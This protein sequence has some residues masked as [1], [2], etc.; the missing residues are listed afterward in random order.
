[1]VSHYAEYRVSFIVMLSVVM[2]NVVAPHKLRPYQKKHG[3]MLDGTFIFFE[4]NQ[5]LISEIS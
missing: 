5:I 4:N 2:Q 1:M 3:S